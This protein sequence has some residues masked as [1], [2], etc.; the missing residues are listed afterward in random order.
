MGTQCATTHRADPAVGE[1]IGRSALAALADTQAGAL[2]KSFSQSNCEPADH[3]HLGPLSMHGQELDA[4]NARDNEFMAVFSHE[5]RN[6]LCAIRFAVGILSVQTS[7][8][9]AALKARMVIE[10]QVAQMTR[11]VEDLFD[12][13]RVRRG[14]L[15]IRYERVDLCVVAGHAAQ[16]VEFTMRERNHRLSTSLP[17]APVWLQADPVRLE[18]VL[19]NLLLNA[20]KYTQP[21]GR[22]HLSA[23]RQDRDVVIGVRDS[24]IGIQSHVLPHVFDLFIQANPSSRCDGSMG[25]GLA[26]VRNLVE[27]HGGRVTAASAGLGHG[28][29]FTVRLPLPAEVVAGPDRS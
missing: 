7:V 3:L 27:Q 5:L 13:S 12:V 16:T 11:M 8:R 22:I 15:D 17:N 28:S 4:K 6:S 29:E 14:Q 10:R 20:A 19:V 21:G 18:Q 23:E 9:P 26:L 1:I 2:R 24:G 25:I